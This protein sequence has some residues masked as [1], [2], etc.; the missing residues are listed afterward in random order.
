MRNS[1]FCEC[2]AFFELVNYFYHINDVKSIKT[3]GPYVIWNPSLQFYFHAV[4]DAAAWQDRVVL[5][6]ILSPLPLVV[7]QIAGSGQG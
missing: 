1:S 5:W 4:R 3:N 6:L 7:V 2:S